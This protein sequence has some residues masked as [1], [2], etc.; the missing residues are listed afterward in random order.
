MSIFRSKFRDQICRQ[1]AGTQSSRYLL[2]GGIL[3]GALFLAALLFQRNFNISEAF[4]I[5]IVEMKKL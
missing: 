5:H 1:N 3:V 4:N 2:A